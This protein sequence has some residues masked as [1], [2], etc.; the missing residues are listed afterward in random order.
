MKKYTLSEYIIF[1][2]FCV[3]FGFLICSNLFDWDY[4]FTTIEVDLRGWFTDHHIPMWSYQFCAGSTRIADPQSFAMSPFFIFPFLFGSFWGAKLIA[5]AGFVFCYHYTK[6][7]LE[8]FDNKIIDKRICALS[9]SFS[10]YFLWHFHHGHL[11]FISIGLG[12]GI[13]YFLAKAFVHKLDRNNFIEFS[14]ITFAILSTGFY[15][16]V[17][18]LIVPTIVAWIFY[19]IVSKLLKIKNIEIWQNAPWVVIAGVSG[20]IIASYKFYHMAKHQSMFPRTVNSVESKTIFDI[21]QNLFIPTFNYKYLIGTN[22]GPWSIWE[23]SSLNIFLWS[24]PFIFLMKE[25]K[26]NLLKN[27][28]IFYLFLS[29]FILETLFYMGDFSALAPHSL[30]NKYVFSNSIRVTGRY[31]FGISLSLSMIIYLFL[32]H[33]ES[34]STRRYKLINGSVVFL[35]LINMVVFFPSIR[36]LT[37]NLMVIEK[38]SDAGNVANDKMNI[39]KFA[40]DRNNHSSSMYYEVLKGHIVPNC[41]QPL[42][43]DV[44]FAG[45][46]DGIKYSKGALIPLLRSS[47]E[48]SLKCITDSY[49]TQNDLH[50][51]D[52]CPRDL[53]LN[54]NSLNLYQRE[55]A[56]DYRLLEGRI[57]KKAI[58]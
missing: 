9:V 55:V 23:Y 44:H 45:E 52:N 49:V 26:E 15:P 56:N 12:V 10:N 41:Y 6:K 48:L 8:F 35:V 31:I 34:I 21:F 16:G 11:T 46:E 43:R 5:L 42:S 37:E 1:F 27:S 3:L 39:I 53:C 7:I 50:I 30:I 22:S 51:D 2:F 24:F 17:I 14:L 25:K 33:R 28:K 13:V 40:R 4:F 19:V 29:L 57:C 36:Y 58:K 54:L 18:Y 38:I 20:A 47:S 32:P